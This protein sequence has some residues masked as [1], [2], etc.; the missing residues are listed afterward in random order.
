MRGTFQVLSVRRGWQDNVTVATQLR[1]AGSWFAGDALNAVTTTLADLQSDNAS[2]TLAWTDTANAF[3]TAKYT[4]VGAT[5][6]KILVRDVDGAKI[7][8]ARNV[9]SVR[10]SRSGKVVT[11]DLTVQVGNVTG[12]DSLRTYLRNTQ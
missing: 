5:A 6:P 3:H 2:T 7:E 4:L 8:L 11:L 10:F 12:S 9:V 1:N